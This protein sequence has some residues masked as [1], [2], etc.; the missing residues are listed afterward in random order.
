M[1]ASAISDIATWEHLASRTFVSLRCTTPVERFSGTMAGERISPQLGLT[2]IRSAPHRVER[3]PRQITADGQ[4]ELLL[5]LQLG[6]RSS[7]AQHGRTAVTGPGAAVLYE[8]RAPYEICLA[9]SEQK[10][11][12]ARISR[13]LLGLSDSDIGRAVARP[14]EPGTPGLATLTA[15]LRSLRKESL[16]PGV[17]LELSGLAG[18]LLAAVIRG[19]GVDPESGG[20]LHRAQLAALRQ[21]MREQLGDPDL[22][23]ERLAAQHFVS[24]RHVHAL[25]AEDGD[26]PG[27]HLRRL[28][29]EHAAHLLAAPGAP[30]VRAVAV[31]CGYP[32]PASFTRA[33]TRHHGVAP[34]RWRQ[35]TFRSSVDSCVPPE[36][37]GDTTDLSPGRGRIR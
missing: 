3:T 2:R 27:A 26:S 17:A 22:T 16:T 24:A 28:R 34:S 23:V 7:V 8:T 5:T 31:R 10:L 14:L 19:A 36:P 33:F 12:I 21:S 32:D 37:T 35:V 13:P 4:D 15:Y 11:L 29:L 30:S 6:G 1:T 18:H 25:F 9:G 20:T